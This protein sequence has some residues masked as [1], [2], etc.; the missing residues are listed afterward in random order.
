MPNIA[1]RETRRG[2]RLPLN[3]SG[4]DAGGAPFAEGAETVNISGGGLCFAAARSVPV[5]ARLDLRIQVPPALQR[6]FGGRA[7]YA[8]KAVVCRVEHLEGAATYK[9]GVRFLG[10]L[11]A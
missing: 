4:R 5:G 10:E 1:E 3:I 8:V 9:I 2:L 7:V 6:H 11:E